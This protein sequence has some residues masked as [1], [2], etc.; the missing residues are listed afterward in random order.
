MSDISI[1][2]KPDGPVAS[3]LL[4]ST[5]TRTRGETVSLEIGFEPGWPDYGDVYGTTALQ[6]YQ[7]MVDRLGFVL[8][9]GSDVGVS[10]DSVP[11]VQE[12]LPSRAPVSSQVLLV[13]PG[14]DVQD[15]DPFW[16][17]LTNGDDSSRPPRGLRTM[18]VEL[19]FLAD[20]SEYADRT[21]LKN[22]IGASSL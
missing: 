2:F 11:W 3:Y 17:A 8:S 13:E 5:P 4:S 14:A 20:G 1:D 21:A 15:I 7:D 12:D 18:T 10:H 22:D 19:V 16:G 6:E 9:Q